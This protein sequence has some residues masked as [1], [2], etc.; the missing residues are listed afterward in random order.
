LEANADTSFG[1]LTGLQIELENAKA[2][3]SRTSAVCIHDSPESVA[4][5]IVRLLTTA[6]KSSIVIAMDNF[7]YLSYLSVGLTGDINFVQ[8]MSRNVLPC[9]SE[10]LTMLCLHS[11]IRVV[12]RAKF[13]SMRKNETRVKRGGKL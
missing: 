10:S 12:D 13:P 2:E 8:E 3:L 4:Q 7:K 6:R 11:G 9:I 5:P 1:Q